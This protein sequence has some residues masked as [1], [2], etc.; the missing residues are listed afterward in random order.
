GF[1]Q[2]FG[3]AAREHDG[4]AIAREGERDG[5]A[6][7]AARAG[8]QNGLLHG[9]LLS[10]NGILPQIALQCGS[11]RVGGLSGYVLVG[12]A[13]GGGRFRCTVRGSRRRRASVWC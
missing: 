11:D 7:A 10:R 2:R 8:N 4:I 3:A 12:G 9:T 1:S 13:A 6:D 5:A